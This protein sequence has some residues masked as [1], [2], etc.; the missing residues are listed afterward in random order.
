[1]KIETKNL[2]KREIKGYLV[3]TS[4]KVGTYALP[5]GLMEASRGLSL[6][7]IIQSRTSVALADAVL[8]RIYGKALNYT[9]KKFKTEG[10]TGVRSYLVDTGTML[11]VY[12]PAYTVILASCG[13]DNDQIMTATA[14]LS[15]ILALTARPFSKYILDNWRR[16]W[17]SK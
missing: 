4:A 5:M 13:A 10:T 16:Y 9:R 12:D 17:K 3:D 6:E 14:C 15:G 8:G 1:M 2:I 7:Q 11:A